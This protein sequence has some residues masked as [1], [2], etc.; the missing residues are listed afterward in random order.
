MF[1]FV[2]MCTGV[3]KVMLSPKAFLHRS[4]T[5][6][7]NMVFVDG[8]TYS[9]RITNPVNFSCVNH[10]PRASTENC[11]L[12][13]GLVA[14]RETADRVLPRL[15]SFCL[16]NSFEDHPTLYAKANPIYNMWPDEI[17]KLWWWQIFCILVLLCQSVPIVTRT[18]LTHMIFH[19]VLKQP[20]HMCRS[21]N[22]CPFRVSYSKYV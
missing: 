1:R 12:R 11:G 22:K 5:F 2:S 4:A 7:A 20:S 13:T 6:F 14:A 9:V 18:S 16:P 19:A 15:K 17:H 10:R 8:S 21:K 3:G